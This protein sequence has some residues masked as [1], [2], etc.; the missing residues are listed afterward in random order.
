M[1]TQD[2]HYH[3]TK[4][5]GSMSFQ[6]GCSET[7]IKIQDSYHSIVINKNPSDFQVYID[8]EL[9]MSYRCIEA[10]DVE[11]FKVW[12]RQLTEEEIKRLYQKGTL[13]K[14]NLR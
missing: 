5:L 3:T 10:I 8:G 7:V 13:T 12:D 9:D 11:Q 6:T 1:S 2:L 14:D 4:L